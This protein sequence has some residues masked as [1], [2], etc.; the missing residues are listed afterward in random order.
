MVESCWEHICQGCSVNKGMQHA[1]V[2]LYLYLYGCVPTECSKHVY[3]GT[4]YTA[5]S[6]IL[7]NTCNL[8]HFSIKMQQQVQ[9]SL[10][11][12]PA[13][14]WRRM[15]QPAQR[16][17][18]SLQERW[19]PCQRLRAWLT[20]KSGS[21]LVFKGLSLFSSSRVVLT[22][23]TGPSLALPGAVKHEALGLKNSCW[24]QNVNLSYLAT[25]KF[26]CHEWNWKQPSAP[27]LLTRWELF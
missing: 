9:V 17:M 22:T 6:R 20:P 25:A 4:I 5:L 8:R 26:C 13:L 14:G 24:Q 3:Y 15:I 10:L 21:L 18:E 27:S 23:T 11:L 12:H 19:E 16:H 2:W 1:V 7:K